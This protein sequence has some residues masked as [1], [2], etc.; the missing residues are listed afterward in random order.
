MF[1]VYRDASKLL[2]VSEE[3]TLPDFEA[4]SET[5]AGAGLLGEIDDPTV[6]HFG[7]M[8][9]EIPFRV[10]DEDAVDMLD[11]TKPVNITLRAAQQVSTVDGAVTFKAMRIVM[12][13][14][15]KS[16]TT[17]KVKQSAMMESSIKME[18]TYILVEIDGKPMVE[19]D[20]LNTVFK[21]KG[22][23]ILAKARAM[24]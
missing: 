20:K 11:P 17:G 10:L 21:I 12:R 19:L 7:S 24:C 15:N 3:V 23:D 13:G 4:L 9:Q 5:I 18:L 22:V 14:K 8:E 1:N 16:L 6:G 2:G